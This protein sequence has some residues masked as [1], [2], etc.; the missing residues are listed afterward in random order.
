MSSGWVSVEHDDPEVSYSE[1]QWS[2]EADP[3]SSNGQKSFHWT[4]E[5]NASCTFSF[6]GVNVT[7]RGTIPSG[8]G[9]KPLE[10]TIDNSP[11]TQI[12]YELKSE[13][14]YRAEILRVSDLTDGSHRLTLVNVGPEVLGIAVFEYY[15][16]G[17]SN[18]TTTLRSPPIAPGV[19]QVPPV[20][21]QRPSSTGTVTSESRPLLVAES[22]LPTSDSPASHPLSTG[23]FKSQTTG[24][25]TPPSSPSRSD[26]LISSALNSGLVPNRT[27]TTVEEAR[28]ASTSALAG[29]RTPSAGARALS[30]GATVGVSVG[31]AL[32][33]LMSGHA[34][35]M[36]PFK[37]V[38]LEWRPGAY[39][40]GN[41]Q[42][43]SFWIQLIERSTASFTTN[44]VPGVP[45]AIRSSQI[46]L[47]M[48]A[49]AV[50]PNEIL[51]DIFQDSLP[52]QLDEKGR[53][54]FQLIRSVC[55]RWRFICF[56]SPI[57]WSSVSVTDGGDISVLDGWFLRSGPSIPLELRYMDTSPGTM[58][59]ED[60]AAIQ[61]LIRRYQPRWRSLSL[62]IE[63]GC[64]WSALTEPPPSNWI[65]LQTLELWTWDLMYVGER[66]AYIAHNVL[67]KITT[68]RCL[69]VDNGGYKHTRQLGPSDL[70]EL[71]ITC[72]SFR[73]D[74]AHLISSYHH[75]TTLTVVFS[76]AHTPSLSPE[77]H[78]VLSS[79][80]SFSYKA[81]N[82][83]VLC[84][85]TTPALVN[86]DIQLY[87]KPDHPPEHEILSGFLSR[88]SDELQSLTLEGCSEGSFFAQVLPEMGMRR[89]LQHLALDTWP[90][91]LP[92]LKDLHADW[93]LSLRSLTVS[94]EIMD[95]VERSE[96][97]EL[98]RMQD[99]A[100][101]LLRWKD[102][103][104]QALE[105]L[106]IH[107]RSTDLN[108]PYGLFEDVALGQ[109]SVM[110][111]W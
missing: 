12:A 93:F 46:T 30:M 55:S 47:A 41:Q 8:Q 98:E 83:D 17:I 64:F 62:Y 111:P 82:L 6:K 54:A 19:T 79:L 51:L 44:L 109:L 68:L 53:L 75:L 78:L 89:G 36:G 16:P 88:C 58:R 104:R 81:Y 2:T 70:A 31:C 14:Q 85:V 10:Y 28:T 18:P 1:G 24:S 95:Q 11:P 86:L 107:K 49:D 32:F 22:Q 48:S 3:T 34:P 59:N 26:P 43:Q 33:L 13:A 92:S 76:S 105:R 97:L 42:I 25:S 9:R 21:D 57:L 71:R 50:L 102:G 73:I 67:E 45:N 60:K 20:P 91:K 29:S 37:F 27:V 80:Y 100:A 72:Y 15:Q 106:T 63:S 5:A 74:E 38:V 52:Q 65:N 108:F 7:T 103:G 35:L 39:D 4:R 99:L 96:G 84:H 94:I 77:D 110:V 61:A 87:A 56:S 40:L 23:P 66:K 90:S 101:F 69:V